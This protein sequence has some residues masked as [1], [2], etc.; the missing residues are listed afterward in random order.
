MF[1][2]FVLNVRHKVRFFNLECIASIIGKEVMKKNIM[3]IV[4]FLFLAVSFHANAGQAFEIDLSGLLAQNVQTPAKT[5]E[6]I[7]P[8]NINEASADEIAQHI[9]GIGPAKAEAIVQFRELNGPFKALNELTQ[10]KGI[11][12][13]TLTKNQNLIRLD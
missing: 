6:N 13:K 2:A 9:K 11:G 10:V 8:L 1:R 4:V 7:L 3:N 12:E 5:G